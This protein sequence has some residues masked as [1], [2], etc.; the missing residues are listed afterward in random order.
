M[1]KAPRRTN[2]KR[3]AYLNQAHKYIRFW[4]P[5]LRLENF[6]FELAGAPEG[7]EY[8]AQLTGNVY[9]KRAIISIRD[10]KLAAPNSL[11]CQDLEVTVVHE[12]LHAR[13]DEV[14]AEL[15]G[16]VHYGNEVATELTAMALVAMRRG[17]ADPRD[18]H[19]LPEG[20]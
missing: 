10:P 14:V 16:K 7:A 9:N 3:P 5:I 12:L 11:T 15:D 13:F 20:L 4:V 8:Y 18:L 1:K 17:I 19:Y 6:E 2:P